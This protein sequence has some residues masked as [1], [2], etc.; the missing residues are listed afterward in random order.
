[1]P[2]VHH[3]AREH[4]HRTQD[5]T[6]SPSSHGGAPIHDPCPG[7]DRVTD[8]SR[9]EIAQKNP[10][11]HASNCRWAVPTLFLP[12]PFWWDAENCPWACVRGS[13]PHVLETT[14]VCGTCPH[15][16]ARPVA[17]THVDHEPGH[18]EQ[19]AVQGVASPHVPSAT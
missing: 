19:D 16:E 18:G 9:L 11:H 10:G 13:T 5:P 7:D 12:A 6:T 4:R 15:W 3:R 2:R 14:E 8:S 1:M 17:A